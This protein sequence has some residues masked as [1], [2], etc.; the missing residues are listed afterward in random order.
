MRTN[1]CSLENR[2]ILF[3]VVIIVITWT[4]SFQAHLEVPVETLPIKLFLQ[5]LASFFDWG[6]LSSSSSHTWKLWLLLF[7]R[8]AISTCTSLL[9]LQLIFL[10]NSYFL[11][12]I[13]LRETSR[14]L[15]DNNRIRRTFESYSCAKEKSSGVENVWIVGR[16]IGKRKFVLFFNN[17]AISCFT[18]ARN[19]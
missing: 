10:W 7:V 6:L 1:C 2:K 5:L 13:S 16:K 9:T 8:S 3:L 17:F 14:E 12:V 19:L 11:R 4:L 18:D 15:C